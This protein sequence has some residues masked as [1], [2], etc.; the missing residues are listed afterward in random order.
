MLIM[1]FSSILSGL[2]V[3]SY[4]AITADSDGSCQLLT[5]TCDEN[6]FEIT[7]DSACRDN[8]YKVS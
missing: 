4:G 1:K 2:V 7:F 8:E 5:A 6:G 3:I